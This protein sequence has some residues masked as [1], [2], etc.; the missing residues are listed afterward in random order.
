MA[1]PTLVPQSPSE[2]RG[3]WKKLQRIAKYASRH[4]LEIS[5]LLYYAT[6]QPQLSCK[7]KLCIYSALL[8]FITPL[9]VVPDFLPL[10]LTDDLAV[11]SAALASISAFI[12]D[13]IRAQVQQRLQELFGRR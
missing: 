6:Q 1:L 11:L 7:E 8:Y 3:F 2:P 12:D 10:G 13:A 4:L 9:D 5:L